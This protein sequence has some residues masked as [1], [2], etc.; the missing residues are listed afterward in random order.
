MPL[1]HLLVAI[2][3]MTSADGRCKFLDSRANGYVRSEGLGAALLEPKHA[4]ASFQGS[5][6]RSDG[7]SASLTA[8]NG[9]AQVG[10]LRAALLLG[11][12]SAEDVHTT[13][14]HGTG[15]AL[16][17][18]IE[19]TAKTFFVLIFTFVSPSGC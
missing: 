2:A 15:P 12:L 18:P 7:K 3:G 14:C 16:G 13:E 4:V 9:E 1:S 19:T 11:A 6:V 5:A 17:D 10:L 8:P